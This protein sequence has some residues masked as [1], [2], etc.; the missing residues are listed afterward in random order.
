MVCAPYLRAAGFLVKSV[1]RRAVADR[2]ARRHERRPAGRDAPG[3]RGARCAR[4]EPETWS[5]APSAPTY[6]KRPTCCGG[7]GCCAAGPHRRACG[8]HRNVSRSSRSLNAAHPRACVPVL[9]RSD[10]DRRRFIPARAKN[11]SPCPCARSPRP[12]HACVYGKRPNAH[13]GLDALSGSSPQDFVRL[14][15]TAGAAI[16]A[17]VG[18]VHAARAHVSMRRDLASATRYLRHAAAALRPRSR[19]CRARQILRRA[20]SRSRCGAPP[21]RRRR[22]PDSST[23]SA[24]QGIRTGA[25]APRGSCASRSLRRQT[26]CGR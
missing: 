3:D 10:P 9:P 22:W 7:T 18:D 15:G 14:E 13:D 8:E 2:G 11:A 4:G 21:L 19:V 16:D 1:M 23:A 20:R 24:L 5:C 6:S 26:A 25:D 12:V 17:A